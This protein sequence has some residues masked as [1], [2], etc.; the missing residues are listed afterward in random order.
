MDNL[1]PSTL[2]TLVENFARNK[3]LLNQY[4]HYKVRGADT[5]LKAGCDDNCHK[6]NLCEIVT[7]QYDDDEK[8]NYLRDIYDKNF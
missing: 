2:N 6:D 5:S 7:T 3:S 4:Y 8:C 1:E